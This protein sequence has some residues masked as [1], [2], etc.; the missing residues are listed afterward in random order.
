MGW[1]GGTEGVG[2]ERVRGLPLSHTP[3]YQAASG[4][5]LGG[6]ELK[7]VKPKHRTPSGWEESRVS[8]LLY[9]RV[10]LG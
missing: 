10:F 5:S 1:D 6:K 4:D 8:R 3:E 2:V 7:E 9:P